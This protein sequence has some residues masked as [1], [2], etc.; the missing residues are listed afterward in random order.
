MT[1]NVGSR[2]LTITTCEV[3]L[4]ALILLP[5][6]LFAASSG[7]G[8][9]T[10]PAPEEAIHALI[11][12]SAHNDTGAL[13]HIF[14][15]EG[16]QI[17]E[18]GDPARDKTDREEFARLAGERLEIIHDPKNPDQVTFSIGNEDWPFPV[19]LVRQNGKWE[20]DS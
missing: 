19:P 4:L 5:P 2:R 14:G 8:P 11:R 18:S 17:A 10:F 9:E 3:L 15:S 16:K 20:F 12:A 7:S 1:M 13:L 6:G